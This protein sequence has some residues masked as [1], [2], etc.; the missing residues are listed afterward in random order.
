MNSAQRH[1][2]VKTIFNP[3]EPLGLNNRDYRQQ[4]EQIFRM[5]LAADLPRSDAALEPD[6]WYRKRVGAYIIAKTETIVCG[7]EEAA[8]LL[9][10]LGIKATPCQTSGTAVA[11][12]DRLIELDGPA[13][14]ILKIER[15]LLNILQRLCGIATTTA[16]YVRLISDTNCQVAATRKTIWGLLDKRA[17]QTG[18]GLTHRLNLS[19]AAMLKENHLAIIHQRRE[20]DAL[21]TALRTIITEYPDLQFVEVEVTNSAEFLEALTICKRL[22][23]TIP[24][25]IM[26]DHFTPDQIRSLL[27]DHCT[28]S[29]EPLIC[30]EASG[31]LH[32]GN[33]R[34]Y[35]QT[36]VDV[37]SVGALTHSVKSADLSLLFGVL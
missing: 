10:P 31:N 37:V 2:R 30:F 24:R 6:E 12:G 22:P 13:E 26:F 19:E 34:E 32:P 3:R 23:S 17:V 29:Y 8:F 7:L 28:D 27:A 16:G 11:A 20:A 25:V 15:T 21:E 35:A 36:G 1:E 18:G 5:M 14:S 4:V 33:L 9:E